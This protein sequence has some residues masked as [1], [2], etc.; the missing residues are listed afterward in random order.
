MSECVVQVSGVW[1][2]G[3]EC[4]VKVSDEWFGGSSVECRLVVCEC[5]V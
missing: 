4:V 1:F 5:V 3:S 2:G